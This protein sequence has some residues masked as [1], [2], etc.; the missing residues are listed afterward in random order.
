MTDPIP[1]THKVGSGGSHRVEL[2]LMNLEFCIEIDPT[3]GVG[4]E[5]RFE[6]KDSD[7]NLIKPSTNSK[8][9]KK[10]KVHSLLIPDTACGKG[11][12]LHVE[13]CKSGLIKE[14][15]E[16]SGKMTFRPDVYPTA[17]LMARIHLFRGKSCL[18]GEKETFDQLLKQMKSTKTGINR[19]LI[20]LDEKDVKVLDCVIDG[21]VYWRDGKQLVKTA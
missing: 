21:V 1:A 7:G 3:A 2:S 11:L 16:S 12:H 19:I 10:D 15:D 14:Y 18:S 20:R 13:P 9:V 8:V 5:A 6:L 4:T 17:T